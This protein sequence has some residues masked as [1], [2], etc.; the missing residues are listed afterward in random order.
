MTP[1]SPRDSCQ[2]EPD[3]DPPGRWLG[4]VTLA[5]AMLLA[6]T[7]WFSATAVVPQLEV[8]WSLSPAQSSWMT[9]AVQLGFVAG[10]VSSV[11]L[12]L[13]DRIPPRRFML[14]G[15]LGAAGVNVLLVLEPSPMAAILLRAATG[16]CL[17][18][19]YPPAMKAMSTWFRFRR[20][21]ALGI[22]VGALTLGSATPHLVNGLGGLDWQVVIVVTSVLTLAG[23]LI[24]EFAGSDGPFPFP[25][26]HFDPRQ[27]WTAVT[28]R[29]V[30]LSS[31]GYFGHMWELYAMWAWFAV[32]Y[33]EVLSRAGVADPEG[34]A[35]LATFAVIGVGALGCLAGGLLGDRWGRSQA[36]SVSMLVSGVCALTIGFTISAPVAALVVGLLWGFWVIADS[37]QFSTVI[38]EVADQTYVGT[39]VTLQLALGFTLTVATIWLVPVLVEAFS[40]KVGFGILAIGPAL[41]IAAMLKLL[42]RRRAAEK[43]DG[44][45]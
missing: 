12:G 40:W 20:G 30:L 27:A 36:T 16:A 34:K 14:Y 23:G 8:E 17:A 6:M 39:A 5:A 41:G 38:T 9:I 33:T 3:H 21:T 32:F 24:A 44:S 2:G 43:A 1:N 15:G 13:A 22:M 19:V 4:L 26:S 18:G 45:V 42:I 28:D 37:A 11:V 10:A 35:A 29:G 25:A 31:A 7:T